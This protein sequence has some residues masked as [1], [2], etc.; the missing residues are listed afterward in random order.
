[1]KILKSIFVSL[2]I[3]LTLNLYLPRITFAEKGNILAKTKIT[4]HSPEIRS[5]KEEDIPVKVVKK[6]SYTLIY[7]ILGVLVLGGVAG[8]LGGSGGGSGGDD[9]QTPPPD[10]VYL[11]VTK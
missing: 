2:L 5:T 7:V 10:D 6:K 8:G 4:G 9:N 3:L 11:T 1:M